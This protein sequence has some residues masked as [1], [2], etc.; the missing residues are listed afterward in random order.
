ME[1]TT[2]K[3]TG[4]HIYPSGTRCNGLLDREDVAVSSG[5][6]VH[7]PAGGEWLWGMPIMHWGGSLVDT[8]DMAV[9]LGSRAPGRGRL[10]QMGSRLSGIT[11]DVVISSPVAVTPLPPEV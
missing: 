2:R 1:P 10:S 5:T 4:I 8:A 9:P 3:P 6:I 7:T 11:V